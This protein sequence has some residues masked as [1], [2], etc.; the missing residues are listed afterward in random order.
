M[1]TYILKLRGAKK[2]NTCDLEVILKAKNKNQAF[3]F[4]YLFFQTG[5]YTGFTAGVDFYM[6]E[7]YKLTDLSGKYFVPR[8]AVSCVK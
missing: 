2:N 5:E 4:A 7:A 6:P 1:K 8:T 3:N